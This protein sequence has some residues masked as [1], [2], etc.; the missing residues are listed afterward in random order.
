MT[1]IEA[2][3]LRCNLSGEFDEESEDVD[4]AGLGDLYESLERRGYLRW[5]RK[6]W[7]ETRDDGFDY[8]CSAKV[9]K[10]TPYGL[11]ALACYVA[12]AVRLA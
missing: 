10:T 12:A 4:D 11:L 5:E 9:Y 7:V 3:E 2:A 8:E 6:R 1:A